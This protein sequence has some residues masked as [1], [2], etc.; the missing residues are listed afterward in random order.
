MIESC[1]EDG[2]SAGHQHLAGHHHFHHIF[3]FTMEDASIDEKKACRDGG[4]DGHY[5]RGHGQP[6]VPALHHPDGQHPG[7]EEEG[8][9]PDALAK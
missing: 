8:K 7:E 2:G 4:V 9:G 6:P 5:H 3:T 1:E